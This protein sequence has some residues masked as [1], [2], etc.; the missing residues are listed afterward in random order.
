L[1][2]IEV[3]TFDLTGSLPRA[4]SSVLILVLDPSQC[5]LSSFSAGGFIHL[6]PCLVFSFW[7]P[8]A[9]PVSP[10]FSS[11][12]LRFLR[13]AGF[14]WSVTVSTSV[15]SEFLVRV[16]RFPAACTGVTSRAP[17][18]LSRAPL[19]SEPPT[20]RHSSSCWSDLFLPQLDT[21]SLVRLQAIARPGP[22]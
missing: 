16:A 13:L 9:G 2:S 11:L 8:P 20:A 7:L 10:L 15:T 5:C 21:S 18:Q 14:S 4:P 17:F 6:R 19:R 22:A 12:Q 3:L 1:F